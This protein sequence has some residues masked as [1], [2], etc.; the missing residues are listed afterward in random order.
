MN[1]HRSNLRALVELRPAIASVTGS[2]N[3]A[4]HPSPPLNARLAGWLMVLAYVC[5]MPALMPAAFATL[6]RLEGSHRVEVRMVGDETRVA[7]AHDAPAGMRSHEAIHHHCL[8]ARILTLFAEPDRGGGPDHLVRFTGSMNRLA[9]KQVVVPEASSAAD[10]VAPKFVRVT[11][12]ALPS[13]SFAHS[14]PGGAE[15]KPPATLHG[16][17]S[18]VLLL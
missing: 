4:K 16:L 10:A 3:W 18:T 9:S 12:I 11:E 14:W 8:F 2:S 17:K 1:I 5:T 13:R 7:L 6:A 15:P